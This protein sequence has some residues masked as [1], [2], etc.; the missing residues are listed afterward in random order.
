MLANESVD[1]MPDIFPAL[2]VSP[3]ILDGRVVRYFI[4]SRD[5]LAVLFSAP[6]SQTRQPQWG[7]VLRWHRF[8]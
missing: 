5:F 7:S 3:W 2:M 4:L 8:D 1:H 6:P